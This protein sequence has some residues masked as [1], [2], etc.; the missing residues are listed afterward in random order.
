[1]LEVDR[2][3]GDEHGAEERGDRR[4]AREAERE[5]AGCDQQ[6]GDELDGWI[7]QLD[8]RLAVATA[9]T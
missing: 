5:H 4:V 9:A 3:D 1:V 7:E 2:R 6:R 8:P